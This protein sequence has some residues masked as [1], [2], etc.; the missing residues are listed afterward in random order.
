MQSLAG[1]H[2]RL[3]RLE[4]SSVGRNTFRW[5][6]EGWVDYHYFAVDNPRNPT[7]LIDPTAGTNF[8]WY[9]GPDGPL[10]RLLQ[11]EGRR[12]GQQKAADRVA[13]RLARGGVDGMLILV[14]PQ[15]IAVYRAALEQAAQIRRQARQSG[16][17]PVVFPVLR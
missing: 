16:L 1:K 15:E 5:G 12:L 8:A 11:Q 17:V 6:R 9:A 10:H 3:P 2:P 14:T 7:L 13:R 4:L